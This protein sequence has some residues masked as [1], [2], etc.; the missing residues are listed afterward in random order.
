MIM[1]STFSF[2]LIAQQQPEG[3]PAVVPAGVDEPWGGPQASQ[4]QQHS[5]HPEASTSASLGLRVPGV[6]SAGALPC[7]DSP[8]PAWAP[9]ESVTQKAAT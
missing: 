4:D 5:E 1:K 6:S 8:A 3:Q 9:T 2:Y 7:S